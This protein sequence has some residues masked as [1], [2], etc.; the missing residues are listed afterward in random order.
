MVT[1]RMG[2]NVVGI[3]FNPLTSRIAAMEHKVGEG[4]TPK[5]CAQ[6]QGSTM[7]IPFVE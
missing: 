1:F 6:D 5:E 7:D 2:F 3:G 4:G